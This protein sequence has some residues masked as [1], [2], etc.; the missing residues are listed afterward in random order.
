MTWTVIEREP[1]VVSP[2]TNGI[3]N[4]SEN[5]F[6]PEENLSNQIPSGEGRVIASEYHSGFAPQAAKSLNATE[7]DLYAISSGAIEL[8]KWIF[9][10]D[11]STE[12]IY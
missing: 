7:Q 3:L 2:P 6:R 12:W 5:S 1:L 8:K 10:I 11:V 4:S 9:S